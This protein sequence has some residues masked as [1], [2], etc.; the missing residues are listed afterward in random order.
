MIIP[1]H[2][3]AVACG[4]CPAYFAFVIIPG[5]GSQETVFIGILIF[6]HSVSVCGYL[7]VKANIL[8]GD[9]VII[10]VISISVF[11]S[12]VTVGK[13]LVVDSKISHGYI[14]P[15]FIAL[16]NQLMGIIASGH[17]RAAVGPIERLFH[18]QR[19]PVF[20]GIAF[21]FYDSET[22]GIIAELTR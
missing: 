19:K 14:V 17:Y 7:F 1:D 15:S 4:G 21:I 5:F 22:V 16:V 9:I 3:H 18:D 13:R 2:R 6:G 8:V 12:A 20:I 10:L 11:E